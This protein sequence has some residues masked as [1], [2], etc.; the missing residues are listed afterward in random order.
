M[1]GLDAE[2]AVEISAKTGIGIESV[3]EAIVTQL[4]P[5]DGHRDQPLKAMLV[6]SWY[7]AYLVGC[8]LVRVIDGEMKK[9]QK[10]RMMSSGATYTLDQVGRFPT[11]A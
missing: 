1:I 11:Q 8:L 4:P 10:I 5:P 3:L 6:D 2:K 9:G 7:D